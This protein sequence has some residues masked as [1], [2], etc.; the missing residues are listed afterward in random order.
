M[1]KFASIT[2]FLAFLFITP[3]LAQS[4]KKASFEEAHWEVNAQ[5]HEFTTYK[6]KKSLYL[7]NGAAQ[8]KGAKLRSGIIEYDILFEE[9][10]KFL[11]VYF[12]IQDERN[13]EEFYV[14]PHQS[15][16]PDAM[17]YTPVFNSDA[18]WQLYHGKGYSAAYRFNFE[19]WMHVR[20]VI[21][22][23]RM[24][25]FINDMSQPILHAHDLKFAANSGGI[26]F[27]AFMGGAYYANLTYQELNNP[28]LVSEV[29][30]IPEMD[31]G[32]IVN[33]QVSQEFSDKQIASVHQLQEFQAKTKLDWQTI[34][35]EYSGL[36]NLSQVALIS[37]ET[38]TVL[39]KT[40]INSSKDQIKQLMIGYSDAVKVY[41][42][43]KAVYS[44]QNIF[45]S[46]DYRYL[47]TIGYFDAVYLDLKKGDN[48][49]IFAVTENFGGWGIKAKLESLEG[50][51]LR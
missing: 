19:E 35:P 34:K 40:T 46:R 31:A 44:G 9:S 43:G 38:N 8:L 50:V 36:V 29:Q 22:D 17:Q 28:T 4:V 26:G 41:V 51:T 18:A 21:A 7:E 1:F 37:E 45:R 30:A 32:T 49:I 27:G 16:N 33:W 5:K 48:E 20:L 6:G 3:A 12:R 47:G 15:G 25:V 11:S 13:Y 24:D 39:A 23:D 42:N 10:R 14:R 2:L